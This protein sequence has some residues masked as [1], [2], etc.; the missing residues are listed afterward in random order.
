MQ[1]PRK[2]DLNLMSVWLTVFCRMKVL[3]VLIFLKISVA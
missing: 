3:K 2:K 1:L